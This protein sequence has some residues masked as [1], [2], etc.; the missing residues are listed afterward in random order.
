VQKELGTFSAVWNKWGVPQGLTSV[1][2]PVK[3]LTLPKGIT[4]PPFQVREQ[5]ER[6]IAQRK[7]SP[8]AEAALWQSLFLTLSEVE[9]L[10]DHVR[11]AAGRT[12]A[13]PLIVFVAH[14]G[15]RRSEIRRSLKCDF[16]FE[17]KRVLIRERKKDHAKVETFRAVPISP[18]LDR[19][20][21]DWVGRHDGSPHVI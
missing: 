3:N 11:D 4:K 1:P 10:L 6:Q 21:R 17:A 18:R 12:C 13:Y 5:I 19:A 8:E 2:A 15:A 9:G 7:L 14:T 16:D 20:V